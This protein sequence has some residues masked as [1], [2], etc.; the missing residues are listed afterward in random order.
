[1]RRLK[2]LTVG[3]A[4]PLSSAWPARG[5]RFPTRPFQLVTVRVWK[6]SAFGGVKDEGQ[7][8]SRGHL[9]GLIAGLPPCV[10]EVEACSGAHYWARFF[11]Q[12]G[13]ESHLMAAKF[14]SPYRMAGKSGNN[15]AADALRNMV[16]AQKSFLPL[17]VQ[18]CVDDLLEHIDRIEANIAEYD[19]ILSRMVKTDHR[20]QRLIE[21][22]GIGPTTSCALVASIGNAH[23]FRNGRQLAV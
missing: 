9:P 22:K 1:M 21:L 15:D 18:Q 20:S 13:H 23:D 3:G 4:S 14:V 16:S 12:Y 2:V 10:I 19:R 8:G 6:A 5:R 17:Q 11:R 7:H